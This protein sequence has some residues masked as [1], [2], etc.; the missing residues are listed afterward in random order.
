[1]NLAPSL[2]HLW[3]NCSAQP[4][5]SRDIPRQEPTDAAREGTCAT[6]LAEMVLT[7]QVVEC[8]DMIDKIHPENGWVVDAA[9]AY[10]VQRYVDEMR[11][12][13]KP[14]GKMYAELSLTFND[15]V[16]GQADCVVINGSHA[17]VVDLKYGFKIVEPMDPQPIIYGASLAHD[18]T[19][20]TV[21][22]GIYQPRSFHPKGV[23]RT[24]TFTS[25]QITNLAY[26]YETA[27]RQ[28]QTPNPYATPGEHCKAC[29]VNDRCGALT[30]EIYEIYTFM[31][32]RAARQ[33]TMQ[34][35]SLEL[36]FAKR[37][38]TMIEAHCKGVEAEALQRVENG[39]HLPGWQRKQNYG[40]RRWKTSRENIM[41]LTAGFDPAGD[42]MVTPAEAERRGVHPEVVNALTEVPMTTARLVPITPEDFAKEFGNE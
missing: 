34:E 30:R 42:T 37:A 20:E 32:G 26:K 5:L 1:M 12:L 40:N 33:L 7:G 9:M 10:H 6:W 38:K 18:Q 22:V 11:S 2:A 19:I 17:T 15:L 3:S 8:K 29:P 35:L 31:G 13:W 21:T 16:H 27:S 24:K 4:S 36:D 41:A 25:E 39:E 28:T 14:G 23:F